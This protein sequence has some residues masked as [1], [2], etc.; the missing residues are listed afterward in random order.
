M[1]EHYIKNISIHSLQN[2]NN[3]YFQRDEPPDGSRSIAR[4]YLLHLRTCICVAIFQKS[5]LEILY[6]SER[7]DAPYPSNW[8]I[9]V[10]LSQTFLVWSL[11]RSDVAC[12][13]YSIAQELRAHTLLSEVF[14]LA[15]LQSTC[16]VMGCVSWVF[17]ILW[18]DESCGIKYFILK[19]N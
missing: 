14:T 18:D 15:P 3:Y 5:D 8:N 9:T 4:G 10:Y 11:D 2:Y 1:T 19:L 12:W 17:E 6:A 7:T 16:L 13:L